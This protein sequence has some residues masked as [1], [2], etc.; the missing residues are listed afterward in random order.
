MGYVELSVTHE[1][2]TLCPECLVKLGRRISV[3]H[4]SRT[5]DNK[6]IHIELG[7]S[8][9]NFQSSAHQQNASKT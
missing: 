1:L 4:L 7:D 8:A 3:G 2:L 6:H 5:D 9:Q